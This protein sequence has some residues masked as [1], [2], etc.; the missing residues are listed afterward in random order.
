MVKKN[1]S[2]TLRQNLVFPGAFAITLC[3]RLEVTLFQSPRKSGVVVARRGFHRAW[4]SRVYLSACGLQNSSP[5]NPL[6]LVVSDIVITGQHTTVVVY[7]T[8]NKKKSCF[9]FSSQG[10]SVIVH[11]FTG[12]EMIREKWPTHQ[13]NLANK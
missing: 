7:K 12:S 1:S 2:Y 8:E 3:H 4:F 6:G 11:I 10:D 9:S 5:E 13:S